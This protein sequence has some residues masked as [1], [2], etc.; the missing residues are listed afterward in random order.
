MQGQQGKGS[1]GSPLDRNQ[2]NQKDGAQKSEREREKYERGCRD[3]D[4]KE[5][6]VTLGQRKSRGESR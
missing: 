2:P 1:G 5:G 6:R 4:G 3:R